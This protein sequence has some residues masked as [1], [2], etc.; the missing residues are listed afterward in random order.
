MEKLKILMVDDNE[1]NRELINEILNY[2]YDIDF[3][4]DGEE[5][6]S[7]LE[8]KRDEYSVVLLDIVMPGL[9]GFD[10][11]TKMNEKNWIKTLPVILISAEYSHAHIDKAFDL[12]AFDF[13][14]RPFDVAIVKRR[15]ENAINSVHIHTEVS[16]LQFMSID[17]DI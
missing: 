1:I 6:L 3:A 17:T 14:S 8:R 9:D 13:V 2:R 12:G 4:I 16:E 7:I 5:A 10:V 11:L 15:I